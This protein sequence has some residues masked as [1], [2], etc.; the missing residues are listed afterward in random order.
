MGAAGR[1]VLGG[2]AGIYLALL[3]ICLRGIER[4]E[5]NRS[6]HCLADVICS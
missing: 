1:Y 6:R 5:L 4:Y 2:V 3:I